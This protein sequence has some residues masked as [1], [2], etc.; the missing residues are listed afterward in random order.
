MGIR[1]G[2]MTVEF[3]DPLGRGGK[4]GNIPGDIC[5]LNFAD[6]VERAERYSSA[7]CTLVCRVGGVGS[8]EQETAA[9][10]HPRPFDGK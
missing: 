8:P 4:P 3:L 6:L 9:Q 2:G 5:W 10:A 7:V 1:T